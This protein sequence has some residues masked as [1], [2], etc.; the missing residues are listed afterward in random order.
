ML[1]IANRGRKLYGTVKWELDQSM[2][3]RSASRHRASHQLLTLFLPHVD[4]STMIA[5]H[6]VSE[7]AHFRLL[8]TAPHPP[9][10]PVH[11]LALEALGP[12]RHILLARKNVLLGI[13]VFSPGR[14]P[15]VLLGSIVSLEDRKAALVTAC[16]T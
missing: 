2:S 12:I 7:T 1:C 5:Y 15:Q 8:P 14:R 11:G 6:F 13:G 10:L 9:S 3:H 16:N 4:V